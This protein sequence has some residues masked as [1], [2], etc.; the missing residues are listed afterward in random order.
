[1]S[2]EGRRGISDEGRRGGIPI[3][4]MRGEGVSLYV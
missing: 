4:L 2:D 1:M 3:C